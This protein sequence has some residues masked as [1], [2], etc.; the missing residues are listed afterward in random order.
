MRRLACNRVDTLGEAV[1]RLWREGVRKGEGAIG[2][3]DNASSRE[4][5]S[6][7]VPLAPARVTDVRVLQTNEIA[8]PSVGAVLFCAGVATTD[9]RVSPTVAMETMPL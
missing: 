5:K 9:W 7:A 3:G 2:H 8:D 1:L 6:L 4:I